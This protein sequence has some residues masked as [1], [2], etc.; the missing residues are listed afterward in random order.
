MERTKNRPI[1]SG[2]ISPLTGILISELLCFIGLVPLVLIGI[3]PTLL[4]LFNILWYNGLYT[5]LKKKTA[6]AVVPGAL[7]GVVPLLIGWTAAGGSIL[8]PTIIFISFF[9]FIWQIPHFWLLLIRYNSDYQKAGLGYLYKSFSIDQIKRIVF[10]WIVATSLTSLLFP[11]FG[12]IKTTILVI[13]IILLNVFQIIAFYFILM[14]EKQEINFKL[15]FIC[16]NIFLILNMIF[17][18]I[19]K[20]TI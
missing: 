15:G 9:I 7:T 1:P 3:I 4:G 10:V 19:E 6:F 17:L 13:S 20:L 12:I 14:K 2:K 11:Y 18:I 16:I 5:Y 8:D